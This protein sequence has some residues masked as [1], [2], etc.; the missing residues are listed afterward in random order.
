MR[1][2]KKYFIFILLGISLFHFPL[3]AQD[4][5]KKQE[6]EK[7]EISS[8]PEKVEV[9]RKVTDQEISNRIGGILRA[10]GWFQKIQ[11][12]TQE[13]VVF[14]SGLTNDDEAKKWAEQLACR[15][16]GVTVVVNKISLTKPSIWD[17]HEGVANLRTLWLNIARAIPSI[18]FSL[19]ILL[20]A[21]FV[22]WAV[23]IVAR[24]ILFKWLQSELLS[25]VFSRGIGILV[26]LIGIYIVFEVA[27][28]TAVAFT[29]VGGTGLLGIILGIAFKDIT[30]NLLASICLSFQQPFRDNDIVDIEGTIGIVQKL[31][32]RATVL[33]SFT[34]N[35]IQIPN[36]LVYKSKIQNYSLSPP[37]RQDFIVG[38]SYGDPIAKAIE[39]AHQILKNDPEILRTPE[40]WVLVDGM[41]VSSVDIKVYFWVDARKYNWL[42]VKSSLIAQVKETFQENGITIPDNGRERLFPKGMTVYLENKQD[43]KA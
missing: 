30:E 31:T 6:E 8:V 35:H 15:T 18:L 27:G 12:K 22:S 3:N 37:L 40:P 11:V 9:K 38:I 25:N 7:P 29:I 17:F 26:F 43:K 10:T 19:I 1:V 24:K 34:G 4:Q 20:I 16:E 33:I 39:L 32:A 23:V 42:K 41:D 2:K 28:L 14:L 21:L 36:S 13:G 5:T